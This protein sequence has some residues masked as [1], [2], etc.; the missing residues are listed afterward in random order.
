MTKRSLVL[1]EYS[2]NPL[3][4]FTFRFFAANDKCNPC[5]LKD[6]RTLRSPKGRN[7]CSL[8]CIVDSRRYSSARVGGPLG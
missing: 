3:R 6:I 2:S 8:F 1:A 4:V 7:I 5:T